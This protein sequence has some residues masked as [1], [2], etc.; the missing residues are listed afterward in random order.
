M[1]AYI[2]ILPKPLIH[3]K[4]TKELLKNILDRQNIMFSMYKRATDV[5]ILRRLC[6]KLKYVTRTQ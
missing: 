1:Q 5:K 6:N 4:I 2:G 3:R